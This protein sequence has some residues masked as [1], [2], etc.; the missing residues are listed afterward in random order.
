[1]ITLVVTICSALAG[2]CET[3]RLDLTG[4]S[5]IGCTMLGQQEIAQA[6]PLRGDQRVREW[7]CEA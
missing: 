4:A 1:M 3:H 5:Y 2:Q 7:K 6:F